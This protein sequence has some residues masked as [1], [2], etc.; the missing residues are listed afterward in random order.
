MRYNLQIQADE[1]GEAVRARFTMV[2]PIIRG[3][4][5][6]TKGDSVDALGGYDK[7]TLEN[8]A[9]NYIEQPRDYGICFEY[10]VHNALQRRDPAI[11][12]LVSTV[13]EDFCNIQGEAE[14]ILFGAEKSGA[15]SIVETAADIL[16]DE[17]RVLVGK[18]GQPP[19]LK[20]RLENIQRAFRSI[21]HRE[22]L[23]QSIRGLWKADQFV[24]CPGPDRWVATTLKTNREDLEP[25]PGLRIGMYPEKRRGMGP[26]QEEN[27]ILCPLPYSGPFMQLFG[28]S[29]QIVKQLVARRGASMPSRVQLVY[30]DDQEVAKWL[31]DRRS[32]PVLGILDALEP[33]AQ[34]GLLREEEVTAKGDDETTEAAAP[35]PLQTTIDFG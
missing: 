8:F 29:F 9:R 3:M 1:V 12:P 26:S 13:L 7:I 23:P 22:K 30:E 20:R 28:A 2:A 18:R 10:A 31:Y 6:S 4:L 27:L 24:G 34:P 5:Y 32:F 35:I 21:K 15:V 17:S 14:S 33:L 16:T 19:L 11:H 25:A